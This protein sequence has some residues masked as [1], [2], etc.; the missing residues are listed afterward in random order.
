MKTAMAIV[1][2]LGF[3]SMCVLAQTA[4]KGSGSPMVVATVNGEP[5]TA[6]AMESSAEANNPY[7]KKSLVSPVAKRQTLDQLIDNKVLA[8]A[9]AKS[10]IDKSNAFKERMAAARSSILATLT[11]DHYVQA[12]TSESALKAYFAKSEGRF[13]NRELRVTHLI[14]QDD[15]T[16]QKV[17]AE[18]QAPNANFPALVKKYGTGPDTKSG[19][20]L[21]WFGR[22]RMLPEFEQAAFATTPGKVHPAVVK[23]TFGYHILKVEQERGTDT[24]AFE[25]VRDRV[26]DAMEVDLRKSYLAELKSKAKIVINEPA[27]DKLGR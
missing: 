16:A 23:T 26:R 20:A 25:D 15:A 21:G 22:G 13:G 3:G 6:A 10:G 27:L 19:G 7:G 9:G 5:I 11:L 1:V 18:A 24:V 12:K 14:V 8:A 4:A 2:W 17:L